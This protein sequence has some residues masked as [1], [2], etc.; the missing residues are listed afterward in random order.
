MN[1]E[2]EKNGY[3]VFRNFLPKDFCKFTQSYYKIRQD[4]LEYDIDD[5]CPR[6]KSFYADPLC[7]TLLKTSCEK[8]SNIINVEL[9]PTYSYTRIYSKKEDLVLHVD[10]PECQFSV[11]V[12]LGYPKEQGISPLY[13]SKKEDGSDASEV[14]LDVGDICIYRGDIIYHWRKPFTQDWYLQTFLH[15]VDKNGVYN[16]RIYDGRFSLGVGKI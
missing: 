4:S 15:Y 14:M 5:Q 12:S 3:V 16:N 1:S 13:M 7:E 6:S 9:L 11:T 8:I 10:R 2:L